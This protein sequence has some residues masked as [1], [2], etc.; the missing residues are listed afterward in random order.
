MKT[1]NLFKIK[2][3]FSLNKLR[4]EIFHLLLFACGGI[5]SANILEYMKFLL[6]RFTLLK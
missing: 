3:R 2:K 4:H 5:F 6:G 1:K